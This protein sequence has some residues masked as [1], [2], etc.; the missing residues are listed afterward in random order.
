[1][2]EY[3]HHYNVERPHQALDYH[4]P[5]EIYMNRLDAAEG[6]GN[7]GIQTW[8]SREPLSAPPTN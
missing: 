5:W 8:G 2:A 4:T 1:M 3:I 6:K 7:T